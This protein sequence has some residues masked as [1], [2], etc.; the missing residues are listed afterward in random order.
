MDSVG[1]DDGQEDGVCTAVA[2][3]HVEAIDWSD[4]FKDEDDDKVEMVN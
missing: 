2:N 4:A 1:A 3:V